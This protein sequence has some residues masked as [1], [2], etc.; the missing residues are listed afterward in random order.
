MQEND[1]LTSREL[2]D[3][4]SNECD[5]QISEATIRKERPK[6]GWKVE[7]ARYWQLVHE[8]NR[9]KSL[10]FCLK[11]FTEKDTFENVIFTDET[12]VQMAQHG[13]VCFHKDGTKPKQKGCP[14]HPLK[15]LTTINTINFSLEN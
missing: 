12:S 14:K 10:A 6:L 7:K 3:K 13:R 15:V 2:K 8:Q 9:I 1:E 5:V 11:A 4:L